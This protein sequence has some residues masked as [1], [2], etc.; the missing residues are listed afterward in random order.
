MKTTFEE[1]SYDF[2]HQALFRVK[3]VQWSV[4]GLT[5]ILVV[6][7]NN[8]VENIETSLAFKIFPLLE[9][10]KCILGWQYIYAEV[11][12]EPGISVWCFKSHAAFFF[13]IV[14]Y[15]K[16]EPRLLGHAVCIGKLI[17]VV[18]FLPWPVQIDDV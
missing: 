6:L 7:R 17:Y 12:K 10:R 1:K 5:G 4:Y 8:C 9:Y 14:T 18:L 13:Y 11:N 3:Q 16:N 15:Y 2:M